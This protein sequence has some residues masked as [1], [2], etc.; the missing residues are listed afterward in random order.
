MPRFEYL[1]FCNTF[2]SWL[3]LI[4]IIIHSLSLKNCLKDSVF[5]AEHA[6]IVVDLLFIDSCSYLYEILL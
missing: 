4:T 3:Q 2:V 6:L 5:F 1:D